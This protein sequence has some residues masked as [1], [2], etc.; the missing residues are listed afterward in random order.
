MGPMLPSHDPTGAHAAWLL[1]GIYSMPVSG[2]GE[3]ENPEMSGFIPWDRLPE[4]A[5]DLP[6]EM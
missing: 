4:S 6:T 1:H 3:T 5:M 2:Y